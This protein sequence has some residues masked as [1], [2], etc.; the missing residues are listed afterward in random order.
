M[1]GTGCPF[2]AILVE[3]TQQSTGNTVSDSFINSL[4]GIAS[5]FDA[6]LVVDE[7]GTA[8]GASGKGFFQYQGGKAD[9]VTFGK[10]TQVSGFFSKQSG[11]NIGG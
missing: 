2:A 3:P 9:Y 4:N 5:D 1:L 7:T 10:R 6:S 11:M 8:A